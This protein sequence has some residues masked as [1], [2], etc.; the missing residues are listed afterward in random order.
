MRESFGWTP[1]SLG[2]ADLPSRKRRRSKWTCSKCRPVCALKH[3]DG[4]A[5]YDGK[6]VEYIRRVWVELCEPCHA[7]YEARPRG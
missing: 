1:K 7:R 5:R 3:R 2:G 4:T 6:R